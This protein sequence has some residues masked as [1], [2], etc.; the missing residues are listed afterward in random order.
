MTCVD[1][2]IKST[3]IMH[4]LAWLSVRINYANWER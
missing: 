2:V 1:N 3:F 4:T